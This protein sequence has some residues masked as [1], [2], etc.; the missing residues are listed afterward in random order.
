MKLETDL[1]VQIIMNAME[2]A[3]VTTV[4]EELSVQII[5]DLLNARACLDSTIF[6]S[7]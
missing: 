2:K 1:S 6:V 3:M 7:H 5:Q 4:S